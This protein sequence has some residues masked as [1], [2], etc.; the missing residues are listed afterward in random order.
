MRPSQ[1]PGGSDQ[2]PCGMTATPGEALVILAAGDPP[3]AG[4]GQANDDPQD[5]GEGRGH[6]DI[7]G[8]DR[9]HHGSATRTKTTATASDFARVR[10]MTWPPFELSAGEVF[11]STAFQLD[12]DPA[13]KIPMWSNSPPVQ[14]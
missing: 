11:P 4:R 7:P 14:S 13:S 1:I 6:G 3:T 9:E 2:P 5:E 12:A 10:R 8:T